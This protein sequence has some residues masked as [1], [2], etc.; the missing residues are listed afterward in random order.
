MDKGGV[1]TDEECKE[2]KRVA[3]AAISLGINLGC[4]CLASLRQFNW[5]VFHA[6]GQCY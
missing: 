4:A 5:K 3:H 1:M 2:R 6:A